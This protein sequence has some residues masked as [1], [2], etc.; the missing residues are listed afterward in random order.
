[1]AVSIF[2]GLDNFKKWLQLRKEAFSPEALNYGLPYPKG[3]L[4]VG[5]QG[6]G[7]SVAAKIIAETERGPSIDYTDHEGIKNRILSLYKDWKSKS[8]ELTKLS[9]ESTLAYTRKGSTQKLA[10]TLDQIS[11]A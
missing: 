3:L 1:M 10:Q 7:K 4:L 9:S 11:K 6:T 8:G 5:V 2:S